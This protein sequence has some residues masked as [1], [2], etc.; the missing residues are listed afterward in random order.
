MA[1]PWL[2]LDAGIITN[3]KAMT[4]AADAFKVWICC[5]CMAKVQNEAGRLPPVKRIAFAIHAK[6]S[7]LRGHS[8]KASEERCNAL[9][10]GANIA[11]YSTMLRASARPCND[12][13]GVTDGA[14][15]GDG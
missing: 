2:K 3:P 8:N 15:A 13:T 7:A 14:N 11:I 10:R 5:L 6:Q 9:R 12:V 4:L 1:E